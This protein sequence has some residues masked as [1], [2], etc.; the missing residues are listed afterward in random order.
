MK[1]T[2][3]TLQRLLSG[4]ADHNI[5]FGDLVALLKAEGFT[6]RHGKGS[7]VIFTKPDVP[8]RITLQ[9]DGSKAKAYQVRQIRVI[10]TRLAKPE[11][12]DDL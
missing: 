4:R 5:D 12:D 8:E 9:A 7:H 10:L 1:K 2:D 3:K 6:E 11:T